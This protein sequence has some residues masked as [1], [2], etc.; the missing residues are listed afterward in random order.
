MKL[1][2]EV[3]VLLEDE[4]EDEE[5]AREKELLKKVKLAKKMA[6]PVFKKLYKLID[7]Y[8]ET[9]VIGEFADRRWEGLVDSLMNGQG[10]P[11]KIIIPMELKDSDNEKIIRSAEVPKILKPLGKDRKSL[12]KLWDAEI[13]KLEKQ[14][15]KKDLIA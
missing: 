7:D 12:Y 9:E 2:K 1:I 4:F 3:A 11:G 5:I 14:M 15:D 13:A 6:A 8:F 10:V